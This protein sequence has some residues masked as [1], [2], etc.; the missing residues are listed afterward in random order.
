M[1]KKMAIRRDFRRPRRV[2]RTVGSA[3]GSAY[4]SRISRAFPTWP[5]MTTCACPALA[6]ETAGNP[7]HAVRTAV[8]RALADGDA[9]M[10]VR[11][12]CNFFAGIRVRVSTWNPR[13]I[14]SRWCIR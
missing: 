3:G 4:S 11:R 5:F 10:R 7:S 1:K 14:T 2:S 8:A 9:S 12:T 6:R 13:V